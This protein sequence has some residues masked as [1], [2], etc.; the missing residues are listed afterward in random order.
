MFYQS[1]K[2]TEEMVRKRKKNSFRFPAKL[3]PRA[4][5]LSMP[6]HVCGETASAD[7]TVPDA[8]HSRLLC[9]VSWTGYTPL[10]V[11]QV[12]CSAL[13]LSGGPQMLATETLAVTWNRQ[14]Y[15]VLSP[16]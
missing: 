13:H 9:P 5:L 12:Q 11:S 1:L 16:H 14:R 8:G 3:L 15:T 4:R 2:W 7:T 10:T 6:A